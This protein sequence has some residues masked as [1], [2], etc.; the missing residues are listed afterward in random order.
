MQGLIRGSDAPATAALAGL[1]GHAWALRILDI[2][3][4]RDG[5]RF[6]ELAN[7]TGASRPRLTAA[8]QAL[9]TAGLVMRNPGYGHPLRPEYLLT[10][11]GRRAADPAGECLAIAGRWRRDPAL[12]YRKWPLPILN[13]IG[14]DDRRFAALKTDLPG[15]TPR[16]LSLGLAS[17]AAAGL[18][19]RDVIDSSPPAV[20]YAVTR[21]AR[22]ILPPL[23]ELATAL[24]GDR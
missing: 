10:E 23:E 14:G 21:P 24:A 1:C 18:V 17:L 8:L 22:P 6:V 19:K 13:A 16:A 3:R 9:I 7:L 11:A 5:A 20:L 12:V 2:L 4:H 15:A